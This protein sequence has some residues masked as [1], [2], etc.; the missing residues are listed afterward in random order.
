MSVG[1]AAINPTRIFYLPLYGKHWGEAASCPERLQVREAVRYWVDK[2]T[3]NKL[4][5]YFFCAHES[6]KDVLLLTSQAR[7]L[8][9]GTINCGSGQ[10][11][12]R[13][14]RRRYPGPS[15]DAGWRPDGGGLESD[16]A[17]HQGLMKHT[18]HPSPLTGLCP[19]WWGKPLKGISTAAIECS[20]PFKNGTLTARLRMKW[21]MSFMGIRGP[22]QCDISIDGIHQAWGPWSLNEVEE[23]KKCLGED[24]WLPSYLDVSE[25]AMST[26]LSSDLERPWGWQKFQVKVFCEMWGWK[27]QY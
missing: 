19:V 10:V 4:S 12:F 11:T 20:L 5:H 2:S 15:G 17:A 22:G 3:N 21:R 16:L 13:L 27:K 9:G 1:A 14:S 8:A 6:R 18:P 25:D 23:F 7:P 26:K 24:E